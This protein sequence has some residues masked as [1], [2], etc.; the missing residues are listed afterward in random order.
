MGLRLVSV[1]TNPTTSIAS[2]NSISLNTTCFQSSSAGSFGTR[3][4]T[5][6]SSL[7]MVASPSHTVSSGGHLRT[8]NSHC[9]QASDIQQ[10]QAAAV[11][12]LTTSVC[13]ILST[14]TVTPSNSSTALRAANQTSI[15]TYGE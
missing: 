10:T 15:L 11:Y 8:S 13:P 12:V 7:I 6:D 9:S 14:T 1:R 4:C 3:V 2:T 5:A